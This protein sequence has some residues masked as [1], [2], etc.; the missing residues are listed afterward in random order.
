MNASRKKWISRL[1]KLVV[2]L[3]ALG[4]LSTKVSLNDTVRLAE[5]PQKK[6]RL[7]SDESADPLHIR[8]PETGMERTVHRSELA[9]QATHLKKDQ[10]PIELGLKTV[11]HRAE[12]S[13]VRW[14]LLIFTPTTFVM[15]WRLRCL[16]ATQEISLSY[17]GALLL[18][19]AGNFFNFAMPG[20]TGGDLYKA[21]HIAKRTQ[22]RTEGITVVLLDR[23]VG[24][25]S[26]LLI[27][28]PAIF[29]ARGT[30]IV[31]DFGRWVGYLMLA[32]IAGGLLF[33]SKR[34]RRLVHYDHWLNRLPFADKLR[35]VDETAFS[36]RYHRRQAALSLIVTLVN[37]FCIITAIYFLARSLGI[38]PIGDR[39]ASELYLAVL[40]STVVGYLFA[41]IPIS[42]QGFGLMEAVF[43][44]VM[45]GGL[46]CDASTMLVLTLGARL[47]QVFWSL[48]GVLVPWLGL[49]RPK[50]TVETSKSSPASG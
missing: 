31:G 22:K 38:D 37:H 36:F 14:A 12:W 49:E 16:L 4:Y 19:F 21:Y 30:E 29:A 43:L 24:L 47:L 35:R 15:A 33:F 27:A 34:L 5:S 23:V 1:V 25:I 7:L 28:A 10:R 44:K 32:L 18:T 8:D 50:E 48:P 39:S 46:W 20:T 45:V 26:F 9:D 2:C 42:V 40:I 3:G 13:W 6:Y 17:R 41:A 11:V